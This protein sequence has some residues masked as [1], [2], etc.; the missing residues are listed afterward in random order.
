MNIGIISIQ[1]RKNQ[2]HEMTMFCVYVYVSH[3]KPFDLFSRRVFWHKYY[4]TV[5]HD[6]QYITFLYT[7][8][9]EYKIK[10]LH[11]YNIYINIL[12]VVTIMKKTRIMQ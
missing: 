7:I 12:I 2:V 9:V 10:M 8:S 1:K 11:S 4:D 5:R 3:N 6:N